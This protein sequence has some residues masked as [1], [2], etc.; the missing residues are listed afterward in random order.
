MV[1]VAFATG[2]CSM[3]RELR[4]ADVTRSET[5]ILNK[6]TVQG[7]VHALR[8]VG[9][10]TIQGTAEVQWMLNSDVYRRVTISG[11]FRFELE[12]DWYSD[13]AEVR[14]LPNGV[15]SGSVAITY[16]FKS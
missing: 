14:Y 2:A 1:T 15:S 16:E 9:V 6:R 10:G 12:G 3:Q 8:I 7:S 4:I 5:L 13:T 11:P